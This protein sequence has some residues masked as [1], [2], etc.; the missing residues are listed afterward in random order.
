MSA[1]CPHNVRT[2]SAPPRRSIRSGACDVLVRQ[3]ITPPPPGEGS[4]DEE[5][6][7]KDAKPPM[8]KGVSGLLDRMKQQEFE[9]SIGYRHIVTLRP[10]A[11]VGEIAL[12]D[13]GTRN[14]TI[15]ASALSEVRHVDTRPAVD[16]QVAILQPLLPPLL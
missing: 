4:D 16:N 14:A 5:A 12:L 6:P 15:R 13:G 11:L 3:E 10:G 8:I 7:P 9:R 1:Q 2:A